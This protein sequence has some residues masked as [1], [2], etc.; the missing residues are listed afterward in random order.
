MKK[1]AFWIGLLNKSN[2]KILETKK[3]FAYSSKPKKFFGVWRNKSQRKTRLAFL[4]LSKD[5]K[6]NISVLLDC[7]LLFVE[8]S[9]EK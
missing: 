9:A 1:G 4:N 5:F 6:N 8:S 2:R 3:S 7:S